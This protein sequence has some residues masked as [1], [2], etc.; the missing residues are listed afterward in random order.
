[1]LAEMFGEVA[2][3]HDLTTFDANAFRQI[4]VLFL[5]E[6]IE[7]K[8]GKG[9]GTRIPN[10][11]VRIEFLFGKGCLALRTRAQSLQIEL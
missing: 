1:M 11:E 10:L 6:K 3:G 4:R 8:S 5:S 9:T 7:I 2:N